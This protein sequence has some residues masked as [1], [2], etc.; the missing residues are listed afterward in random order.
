MAKIETLKKGQKFLISRAKYPIEKAWD[1]LV[2]AA[3][4]EIE[5]LEKLLV[6]T[7]NWDN[8]SKEQ[9]EELIELHKKYYPENYE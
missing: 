6:D 5:K 8:L 7:A 4:G 9:S 1:I 3:V 2:R